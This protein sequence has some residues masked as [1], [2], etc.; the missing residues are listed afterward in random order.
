MPEGPEIKKAVDFLNNYFENCNIIKSFEILDGRY[1]KKKAPD[2]WEALSFPL[3]IKKAECK[4]KFIYIKTQDPNIT[5]WNTFGLS[6]GWRRSKTKYCKFKIT[7]DNN[8]TLFYNDKLGYGTL[9]VCISNQELNKKLNSLGLD[10]LDQNN[11]DKNFIDLVRKKTKRKDKEIGLILMDQK[12]ACGCGNYIRADT[13]YLAKI[14]P[15][16]LTESITDVELSLI[17]NSL[18]KTAFFNYNIKLGMDQNILKNNDLDLLTKAII[19]S[20]NY[21]KNKNQVEKKKIRR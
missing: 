9:K 1:I 5:I 17:W 20:S 8:E 3:E 15:F 18:Q 21:D 7:L 11:T 6:G 12:I 10:I 13:L 19:Y 4:G 14:N 2:N 16:R